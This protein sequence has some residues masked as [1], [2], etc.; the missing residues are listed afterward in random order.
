M[1]ND[2]LADLLH[3]VW[4]GFRASWLKIGNIQD[5][6]FREDVMA[7]SNSPIKVQVSKR[8]GQSAKETFGSDVRRNF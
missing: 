8:R 5:A 2:Y 4:F 7:A 1:A 6:L 3:L